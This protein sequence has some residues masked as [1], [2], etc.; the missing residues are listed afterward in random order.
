M[1]SMASP[2]S[3]ALLLVPGGPHQMPLLLKARARGLRIVCADRNPQCACATL[4]DE[5]HPIGLDDRGRLLALART[6]Q[7]EGIVTD[8]TDS[9]VAVVAWLSEQMGLRGIGTACARLF[10]DKHAM[11][12]FGRRMGLPTP[13]SRLCADALTALAAAR[14]IGFPV[15]LKPPSNQ[16]SRGVARAAAA[17][18]LRVR[19]DEARSFS[20]SGEVLVEQFIGGTEFSVEGVMTAK[21]H[22]TLAIAEKANYSSESMVALRLCYTPANERFDYAA[23]RAVHDRWINAS[24]LPF[25]L[26]HAEYK[27][28]NGQFYLIEAAARGGGSRIASDIVP[29]AS[30][31]DYQSLLLDAILGGSPVPPPPHLADRCALLEF[32]DVPPGKVRSIRG[33]EEA[34]QLPGVQSL[35]LAFSVGDSIAPV[36]DDTKRPGSFILLTESAPDLTVLRDRVL[37]LLQVEVE[38]AS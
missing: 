8:Q 6:V 9:G 25:G 13:A 29:W 7:P 33:V 31:V 2:T 19:F 38:A 1:S 16:S 24:R 18:D 10:T 34:R 35:H 3:P 21:G 11:R 32:L 26:T 30:G 17:E 12:E 22:L 5:F 20:A 37:A 36:T 14:E 15:V 27:H 23:L 4:A 28:W